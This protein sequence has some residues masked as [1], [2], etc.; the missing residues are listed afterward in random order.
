MSEFYKKVVVIGAG[1]M[2]SGIAAHLANSKIQTILLDLSSEGEDKNKISNNAILNIKKSDPPL[3]IERNCL[4]Y[5]QAGNLEDDFHHISDADWIIEAVVEKIEIK[6][7]LYKKIQEI[8][9]SHSIVS[10]NTS[11]IPLSV[12][13][14]EMSS[15]MKD[16]FCITHFFNPVRFMRLLEIVETENLDQ[17]K[18]I[19]T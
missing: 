12:L 3:L 10:S 11:T 6:H 18:N 4:N 8:R 1:T 2:G 17:K 7:H 9:S 19:K 13:T 15:E 14:Q 16:N 5:I